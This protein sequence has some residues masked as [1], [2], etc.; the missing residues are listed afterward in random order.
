MRPLQRKAVV[1]A[2]DMLLPVVAVVVGILAVAAGMLAAVAGMLASRMGAAVAVLAPHMLAAVRLT[3]ALDRQY[4]I[5]LHSQARA[6]Q[7][8][9][10]I[11][12]RPSALHQ[13]MPSGKARCTIQPATLRATQT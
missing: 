8:R 10:S 5:R 6:A 12:L 9:A 1:A 2:V 13:P 4:L 11:D 3:S 7:I